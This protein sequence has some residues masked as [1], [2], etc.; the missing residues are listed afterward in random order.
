MTNEQIFYEL[1]V[2]Y[3]AGFEEGYMAGAV[4]ATTTAVKHLEN[5]FNN[6]EEKAS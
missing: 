4:I 2:A 5:I 3:E 6:E 1:L